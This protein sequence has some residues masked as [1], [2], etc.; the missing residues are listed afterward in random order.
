MKGPALWWNT[1]TDLR[2]VGQ[3]GKFADSSEGSKTLNIAD[4][5]Y[6]EETFLPSSTTFKI[7][8]IDATDYYLQCLSHE[9]DERNAVGVSA[10]FK[11]IAYY[12]AGYDVSDCLIFILD[13][14]D[15]KLE[16]GSM[17]VY[18]KLNLEGQETDLYIDSVGYS[19]ALGLSNEDKE[20]FTKT[21]YT[22]S[23]YQ[24]NADDMKLFDCE[25]AE[26]KSLCTC[27]DDPDES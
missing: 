26:H 8:I 7:I 2:H 15:E 14:S 18:T 19:G 12:D 27:N 3:H 22:R 13:D 5:P 23:K 1:A 16:G 21:W 17:Y 10:V 24:L 4:G 9:L 11:E 25:I 20:V 6:D